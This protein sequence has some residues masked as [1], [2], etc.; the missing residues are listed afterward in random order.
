M[1]SIEDKLVS[2]DVIEEQFVCDLNACKGACCVYGDY[3]APLE[4]AELDILNDVYEQVKPY[5]TS[6]GIESIAEGGKYV[7]NDETDKYATPLRPDGACA[8]T[9]FENG[10]ALCGIEKAWKDGKID[11]QKPVSCHLYPIRVTQH[12][13]YEA[14]NY[15]RWNICKAACKNGNKLKVPVY[16]FLKDAIVRKYGIEFYNVLDEFHAQQAK[17]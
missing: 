14:V 16:R 15:E 3:G 8:Y 11:F 1:L 12:K 9:V 13:Y 7:F 5:L 2:L 17:R 4:A 10:I 6:E